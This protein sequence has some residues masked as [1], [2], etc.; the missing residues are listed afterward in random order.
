MVWRDLESAGLVVNIEKSQWEP[1][2]SLE[3]LGFKVNLAL[4]KFLVPS[5]KIEEI[6]A[7]LQ[8]MP[9]E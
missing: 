4:R 6:Q 7:L 5:R 8:R 2:E 1:R 3:W 9:L